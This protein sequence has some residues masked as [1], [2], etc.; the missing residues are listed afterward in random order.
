[1]SKYL[2]LSLLPFFLAFLLT[3]LVRRAALGIG[4]VD[5][6]DDRRVHQWPIARLGG[7][8]IA[9][10]FFFTF[11][12]AAMVDY[13]FGPLSYFDPAPWPG[14]FLG[15]GVMVLLGAWDDV[16]PL[17]ASTKFLV[18]LGAAGLALGFGFQIHALPLLGH[19]I[20]SQL[21]SIPL[22]LLWILLVTNAFNL[23][24]GLDGLSGGLA[25]IAGLTLLAISLVRGDVQT[26]LL[27][28]VL[29]GA[30]GGFLQYNFH[31]ASIFMGDSGSL[32]LGYVLSLIA[33][34]SS[35]KGVTAVAILAPLLALGL[36]LFDTLLA[37]VRRFL[38][39]VHLLE[40]ANGRYRLLFA[41]GRS[42]FEADRDHVHHRLLDL[43]LSHRRAVL[44]L[45]G[46]ASPWESWRS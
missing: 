15:A 33:L 5:R 38:R 29:C 6:P 16:R 28:T 44:C 14:L 45:H 22:T 10:S 4:A 23:I 17:K 20:S 7:V 21:L 1:V 43:G 12:A 46:S 35:A 25:F 30:I 26:A 13:F 24:D 27:V 42:L 31:P 2:F 9:A 39:A 36:P 18:Q 8:A 19:P 34:R 37:V 3:P 32:F 11:L 41:G 40:V